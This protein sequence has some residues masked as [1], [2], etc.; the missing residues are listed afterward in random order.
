[1]RAPAPGALGLALVL[2]V[3]SAATVQ[4]YAGTPVLLAYLAVLGAAAWFG[5]P[6][7]PWLRAKVSDRRAVAAA[8]AT[9]AVLVVVFAVAYPHADRQG[10]EEGSDR[11]DAA[12]IG[13]Q[14]LLDGDYPY[15]GRTYLGQSVSQLPG[16]LVLA[17]PFVALGQ[18]A[19]AAFFWLPVL[20]LL[21]RRR[22][23]EWRTPLLLLLLALCA[24][25]GL[26][27]ELVTG[28]DLIANG[29]YVLGA[30]WLLLRAQQPLPFA[31]AAVA[32]GFALSSRLSFA[33]VLP[34]LLVAV[35]YRRGWTKAIA[36]GGLAAAAFAAI[37]LPF[38][39]HA[40]RFPPFEA[41][42]HLQRFDD[43]VPGGGTTIGLLLAAGAV[44]AAL[45]PQ[46]WSE[47]RFLIHAAATQLA[48]VLSVVVYESAR[49]A[50]LDFAALVPGYGLLALFFG[51]AATRPARWRAA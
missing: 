16:A 30:A 35:A 7:L 41:S 14:L 19:Y 24:S 40:G 38:V 39:L 47:T 17:A 28:G 18:S 32:L 9:L 44:A 25:P 51:L 23:R 22:Y 6:A 43:A 33:F 46:M 49:N 42:N 26:L 48:L 8:L 29:I 12:D 3:A 1:V 10:S 45:V 36:A 11:D 4:K 27:R 21:L 15:D 20:F 50:T 2:F 13:A 5:A 34:A 31:L 37:T